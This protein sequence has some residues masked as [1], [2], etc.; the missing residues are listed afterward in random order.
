MRLWIR[1]HWLE[2]L[3]ALVAVATAMALLAM[4]AMESASLGQMG[5]VSLGVSLMRFAV[6]AVAVFVMLR[7]LDVVAR[8]DWLTINQRIERNAMASSIYLGLRFI[9]VAVL[10]GFCLS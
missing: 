8:F 6:A 1:N 2:A 3:A 4:P 9:A 10:A 5:A 7:L